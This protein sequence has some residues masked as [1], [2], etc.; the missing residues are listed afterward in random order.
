[1]RRPWKPRHRDFPTESWRR[2][3]ALRLLGASH[4]EALKAA[5]DVGDYKALKDR[6]LERSKTRDTA[7][8]S[9][10]APP[11]SALPRSGR[12]G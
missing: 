10:T 5:E 2:H 7:A 4:L 6:L 1:M 3:Q 8:V 11:L 12:K 9:A